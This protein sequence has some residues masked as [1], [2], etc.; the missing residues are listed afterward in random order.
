M[1]DLDPATFGA[2]QAGDLL[3]IASS[4]VMKFGGDLQHLFFKVL[5]SLPSGV[6]VQF[7]GVHF[8]FEYPAE[9]LES[10]RYWNESYFLRGFLAYNDTWKILLF[11]DYVTGEF[12][13]FLVQHMPLTLASRGSSIY[14]TRI[15]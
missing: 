2:L 15:K 9:W 3:F 6:I 14:L 8:P 7:H 11:N 12:K 4:H 13:D 5:P 10:G 1:Q